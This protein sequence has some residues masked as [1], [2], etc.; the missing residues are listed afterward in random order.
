MTSN[1]FFQRLTA[2][3][4]LCCLLLTSI[5]FASAASKKTTNLT[6]SISAQTYQNRAREVLKEIN[7]IREEEG[8]PAL[9]MTGDLEKAAIQRA[10]ELFVLFDHSRPDMTDFDTIIDEYESLA[11]CTVVQQFFIFKAA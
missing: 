8:L 6:V 5:P 10:G 7:K 9:I 2:L 1:R 3:I 4:L 11:T